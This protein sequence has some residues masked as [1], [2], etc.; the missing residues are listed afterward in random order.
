MST[1]ITRRRHPLRRTLAGVMT[2]ALAGSGLA[3]LPSGAQAAETTPAPALT[4]K[5]SQQFVDHLS[6]RTTS[7]GATYVDGTGF[8][9]GNGVGYTDSGNGV[10][11]IAYQGTV[12]G[13]FAAQ[14]TEFYSVTVADPVVTVDAEGEGT[15]TAVVSSQNAASPQAAAATSGPARVVVTTFDATASDWTTSGG[16]R[17]LTDTPDWAGVL[18][19][20][21]AEATELGI[22][23]GKPV[24]GK[25]FAPAFL[26]GLVPGVRAHFYA[27]GA[28]S[29]TKKN[30]APFTASVGAP[31]LTATT[32]SAT[33]SGGLNLSVAGT[34]FTQVTKPGDA[35][36]YVGLAPS[37][38]LPDTSSNDQSAFA[39]AA[40]VSSIDQVTGSFTTTLNAP[41][42]KL[43]PSKTYSLYTWRAHAHS[44]PS[45][46]TETPVAITFADLERVTSAP[47]AAS[48]VTAYGSDRTLS[49]TVPRVGSTAPTGTV[50]LS[51]AVSQSAALVGG[52]ATFQLPRTLRA[53]ANALTIAYSGD[54][55]YRAS[56]STHTLTVAKATVSVKRNK[57]AKK[58]TSRRSGKT[59]LTV[60]STAG[61]V[62]S[63]KVTVTFTKKGQKTKTKKVTVKNGKAAVTIP[64][65]ARGTWKISV[66]YTGSA[67]YAA[68][69]TRSGGS[70]KVKK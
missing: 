61:K 50:T 57:I 48:Q 17:T 60:G 38:G 14:G 36:V 42:A 44:T 5:I 25:A 4:W 64:R 32:T 52:T 65:L 58:P 6:S 40:W 12:R 70:L 2:T 54:G 3:L 8:Q 41:A 15:V 29:D 13:A 45:Q 33:P 62:T 16:T 68:T 30:P 28:T 23:T 66:R 49:V 46:D 18:P 35:G 37:G 20:D 69:A 19:A 7:G 9:F 56:T 22:G 55:N 63:G 1:T 53:G 21:S 11:R 27:S 47:S 39:A 10:S 31:A 24:D 34:G 51:G 43:D 59:S 67:D 26:A